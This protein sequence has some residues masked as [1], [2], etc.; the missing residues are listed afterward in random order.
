LFSANTCVNHNQLT[1]KLSAALEE[2]S[3][4]IVKSIKN[5]VDDV[6]NSAYRGLG[7]FIRSQG[8]RGPFKWNIDQ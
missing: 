8:Y 1:E 5:G 2:M 7:G 6:Q 4:P 3:D